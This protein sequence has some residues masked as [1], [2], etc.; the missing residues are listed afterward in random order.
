V[1]LVRRHTKDILEDQ[2]PW[3]EALFLQTLKSISRN[4]EITQ[5]SHVLAELSPSYK[6][7]RANS[8]SQQLLLEERLRSG[9][10]ACIPPL[11][12]AP[13]SPGGAPYYPYT[14]TMAAAT[15]PVSVQHNSPH[16]HNTSHITGSHH[17]HYH[18]HDGS[19]PKEAPHRK[20]EHEKWK[21]TPKKIYD[22]TTSV[23][24]KL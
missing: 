21:I 2:Q 11:A 17:P 1:D 15:V 16:Q 6:K 24:I 7:K 5:T 19:P 22:K 18:T 20:P 12:I 23:T 9:H 14:H 3:N 10:N 8:L 4:G 13:L